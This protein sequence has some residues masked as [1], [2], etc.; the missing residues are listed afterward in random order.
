MLRRR[1]LICLAALLV[2][3]VVAMLPSLYR[4]INPPAV[5]RERIDTD[6]TRVLSGTGRGHS[7]RIQG[8]Q[9]RRVRLP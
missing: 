3:V 5:S 4:K 8:T 7:G 9:R 6:P 1:L 2:V